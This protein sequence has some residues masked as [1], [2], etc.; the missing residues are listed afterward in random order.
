MLAS[1]GSAGGVPLGNAATASV[2][3][4]VGA[5]ADDELSAAND[6]PPSAATT[7]TGRASA[8]KRL[9]PGICRQVP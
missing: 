6:A 7:T 4:A 8:I 5:G 2:G 9:R 3:A 1:G